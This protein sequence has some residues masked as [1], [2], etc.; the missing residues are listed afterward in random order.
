MQ[1]LHPFISK[2]HTLLHVRKSNMIFGQT[3]DRRERI[4]ISGMYQ[5]L[6]AT[7]AK[8]SLGA[9]GNRTENLACRNMRYYP[10]DNGQKGNI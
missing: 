2:L 8:I 1:V 6:N 9:P 7:N 3:L 10:L 4:I 5:R